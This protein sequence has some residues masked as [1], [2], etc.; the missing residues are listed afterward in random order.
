MLIWVGGLPS[1]WVYVIM[2]SSKGKRHTPSQNATEDKQMTI[3]EITAALTLNEIKAEVYTLA[4]VTSTRALQ[5][6]RPE[7]TDGKRLTG[8]TVWA[9]ILRCL[10]QERKMERRALGRVVTSF[11]DAAIAM[12]HRPARC[13]A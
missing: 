13:A 10:R 4:G 1:G 11:V 6:A 12:F 7:L 5:D 9:G 2:D 3:T 8:K